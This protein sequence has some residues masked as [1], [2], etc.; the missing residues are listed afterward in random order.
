MLSIET[1]H[2]RYSCRDYS[3]RPIEPSVFEPLKNAVPSETVG[4]F[5]T[6]MRFKI[7]DLSHSEREE[8]K[9]LGTYGFIKGATLF[10]AAAVSPGPMDMVD[11][12]HA[13]E[14]IILK[15]TELGLGT[16][17]MGLTF[18]KGGFTRKMGLLPDEILPVVVPVGYPTDKQSLR[19]GFI[20]FMVRSNS[21]KKWSDLFFDGSPE[22]TLTENSAGPYKTA[23]E[24]VRVAPSASNKQPWRLVM[25]ENRK[26]FDCYLERTPNYMKNKGLADL[27][28]VDMGIA[29]CHFEVAAEV[30]N[31]EG[32][33]QQRPPKVVPKTWE[34]IA[35][36]CGK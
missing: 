36:W 17:W 5:G 20:R 9:T 22:N 3:P 26:T 4:L 24:C 23:I 21:R 18:N 12:G 19:Q 28:K 14:R 2:R 1:I 25:E 11:F 31:L 33:W 6:R 29:L 16:C 35:S 34:Y 15:A 32:Q 30:L 27:Q 8:L 7:L 13:M 10:L